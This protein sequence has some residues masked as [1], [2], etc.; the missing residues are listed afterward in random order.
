M[1]SY[2]R[3]HLGV[4]QQQR[5][6]Q[7]STATF[8]AFELPRALD[9][10]AE[11]GFRE[12]ELMVTR[13][14]TT[15]TP[16]IPASLAEERGLRITS[17]HAPFLAVTKNVWGMDPIAKITRGAEMCRALGATSMVVHPPYLW[18]R[19]YT[20]WLTQR[21]ADFESETGITIAVETM[22]PKWVAGRKLRAYRWLEPSALAAAVSSVALDTSHL[23]V[24]RLDVLQALDMVMP[25]LTHVHLSDNAGDGRDSHLELGQGVLPIDRFLA[26]LRRAHYAGVVSLELSVRRYVERP[27]ALVEALQRS[28]QYVEGKLAGTPKSSKGMPRA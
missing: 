9:L 24:G 2:Q 13:D 17:L 22:Y 15:H 28:R 12:I 10:I 25:K 5:P 20:Q 14:R 4:P 27:K 16:D 3:D 18:E 26:E 23:A 21:A 11:A 1:E 19:G 7:C 6:V 8:W